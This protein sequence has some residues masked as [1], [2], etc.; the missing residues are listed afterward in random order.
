ILNQLAGKITE[1]QMQQMNYQVDVLK[2]S[3]EMVAKEFLEK[4]HL[5]TS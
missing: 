2:K 3:P 1:E 5:L 4:N